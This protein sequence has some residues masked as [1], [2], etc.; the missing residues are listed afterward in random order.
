LPLDTV[1]VGTA[2]SGGFQLAGD[3]GVGAHQRHGCSI[4]RSPLRFPLLQVGRNLR[5]AAE[6]VDVFQLALGRLDRLA[7]QGEGLER[8][9]EPFPAFR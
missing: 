1:D 4:E 7:E 8:A 3:V 2:V 9:V 5:I 6:V